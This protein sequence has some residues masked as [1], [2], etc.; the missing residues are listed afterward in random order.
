MGSV[1]D[2]NF[3]QMG[4]VAKVVKVIKNGVLSGNFRVID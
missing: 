1:A 3:A 4:M 2:A